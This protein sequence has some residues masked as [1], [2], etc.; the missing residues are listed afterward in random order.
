MIRL[1]WKLVKAGYIEK[2]NKEVHSLTGLPQGGV[3]SP[4]LSN[5]YLHA[6]DQYMERLQERY[7]NPRKQVHTVQSSKVR[8]DLR[9]LEYRKNKLEN[10]E[11]MTEAG[12]EQYRSIK[13]EIDK[14]IFDRNIFRKHSKE[15]KVYYVRYADDF[16]VGIIGGYRLAN[17]I[18]EEIAKFLKETLEIDL[19]LEKTRITKPD[20]DP[21]YFLGYKVQTTPRRMV[22]GRTM[23]ITHR[24]G[25]TLKGYIPWNKVRICVPTMKLY[26]KLKDKGFRNEYRPKHKSEWIYLTHGEIL[27]KYNYIIRGLLNYYSIVHDI[28]KLRT[29]L[30]HLRFSAFTTLARKLN[31][32]TG[33]VIAKFGWLMKD[34]VTGVELYLPKGKVNKKTLNYLQVKSKNKAKRKTYGIDEQPNKL[35]DP[36]A[37]VNFKLRTHSAYLLDEPCRICG[38]LED[39]QMH[40]IK[41]VNK[42][43][44]KGFTKLMSM[45]N[46]KQIPVCIYCHNK[47]HAGAYDGLPLNTLIRKPKT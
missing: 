7:F 16:I 24:G 43:K 13:K 14:T 41:H 37:V 10:I 4:L 6:F 5:I 40:H 29:I 27:M 42:T 11:I 1:Y 19:N 45:L 26:D 30:Y 28:Y 9:R 22:T 33:K 15:T 34:P 39:I 12:K 38:S 25:K 44:A 2:D 21:I 8:N 32:N 46:R 47:I 23:S 20:K 36:F 3:L 31:L 35:G 18:R 17:N